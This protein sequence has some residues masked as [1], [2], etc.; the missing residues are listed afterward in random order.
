MSR[1][2]DVN[3]YIEGECRAYRLEGLPPEAFYVPDFLSIHE[4]EYLLKRVCSRSCISQ[5]EPR[6]LIAGSADR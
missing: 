4:E 1:T 2:T 3:E 5:I 6:M